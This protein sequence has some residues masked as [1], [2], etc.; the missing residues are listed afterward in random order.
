MYLDPGSGSYILQILL[1]GLLGGFFIVRANWKRIKM[2][3]KKD[4]SETI[5]ESETKDDS[6]NGQQ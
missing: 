1:A 4:K 2:M 3:F 5:T 6:G